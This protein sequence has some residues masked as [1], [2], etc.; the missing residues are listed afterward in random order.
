VTRIALLSPCY[1]P[2]VRRGSER[3]T[4]ELADGLLSRGH[5]PELITSHR[6]RF[7]VAA[8]EGLRITRLPRPP[9]ARLLRRA[10]QPY[11]THVPLSYTA[12][13]LGRYELAH[14]VYP[15]DALAAARWARTTGRPALLS[16]MG[17]PDF[18]GIRQYRRGREILLAAL[19]GCDAVVALSEYAAEAFRWWLGYEA[20]VIAPG[21]DLGAFSPGGERATA[22]TIVCGADAA[23]PRKQVALLVAALARVRAELPDARLIL[24]RPAAGFDAARRAGVEIDAPGVVWR[25]LDDR[26]AL[27]AAYREAWVAALPSRSEAFGL[28]LAEALAC[29]TPA[30]GYAAGAIPE[31]VNSPA[32]GRLF[33]QATPAAVAESLLE[34]LALSRSPATADACRARAEAFSSDATTDAYLALYRKLGAAP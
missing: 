7:N 6:G 27:A 20:A 13:R 17:I 23:E 14:A 11:L 18:A 8:E 25:E 21:V 4:R 2:E 3:F 22:P 31:V 26:D 5:E 12:L 34:G 29:G 30:V 16:Y 28:V 33:A 10:Y 32:I 24:S 15:T 9:Q 1:W 19:D